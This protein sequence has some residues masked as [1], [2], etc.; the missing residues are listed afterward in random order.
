MG[1]PYQ[2]VSGTQPKV[3]VALGAYARESDPGPM[4]IPS[5]ALIEGYPHPA[6]GDRHVLVL[7]KV[8]CWLYELYNAVS[9]NG[10]SILGGWKAN[11]AAVWDIHCA[12]LALGV[13]R[14]Q[15]GRSS[16][17]NSPAIEIEGINILD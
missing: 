17:V 4:P 12:G 10:A 6:D 14:Y 9:E 5:N 15:R 8:G 7:G 1:I 11:S 3:N 16:D 13:I 2:I